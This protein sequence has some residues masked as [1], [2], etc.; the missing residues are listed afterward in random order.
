[1]RHG[2]KI[3]D[4]PR[5][6]QVASG[7]TAHGGP[8]PALIRHGAATAWLVAL[9]AA[10]SPAT[11]LAAPVVDPVPP[12]TGTQ[13]HPAQDAPAPSAPADTAPDPCQQVPP[14]C[15]QAD[16]PADPPLAATPPDAL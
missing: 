3:P 12:D 16:P 9:V 15:P 8:M 13:Q 1:M 14:G 2:G 10:A 11:V 4:A 5:R 6:P 7:H